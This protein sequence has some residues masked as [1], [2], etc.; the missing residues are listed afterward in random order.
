MCCSVLCRIRKSL[1]DAAQLLFKLDEDIALILQSY[2][3]T[4]FD[5]R[6]VRLNNEVI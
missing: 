1:E 4:K 2:V 3:E 6:V 5:V